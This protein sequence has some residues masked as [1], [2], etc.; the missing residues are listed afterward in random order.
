MAYES[1]KAF[2]NRKLPT[3]NVNWE[4]LP[5]L[6]QLISPPLAEPDAKNVVSQLKDALSKKCAIV[7]HQMVFSASSK[8]RGGTRVVVSVPLLREYFAG[9]IDGWTGGGG[10]GLNPLQ[11]NPKPGRGR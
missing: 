9:E 8:L 7:F 5:A 10:R 11:T 3:N 2:L 1:E 6:S 4:V